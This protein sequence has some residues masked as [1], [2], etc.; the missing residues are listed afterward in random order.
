MRLTLYTDYALRVLMHAALRQP[1]RVTIDEVA[2]AYNISRNHLVKVVQDLGQN[3]FLKTHR[4]IGGGFILGRPG[5]E[6]SLGE[7]IRHT[8]SDEHVV[9]CL[10]SRDNGCR[11][12]PVCRL[13]GV[14]SEASAAFFKVLDNYTIADLVKNEVEIK[15]SLGME[16]PSRSNRK[17][18]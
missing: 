7:V 4:G 3:G 17:P 5:G 10:T 18:L 12:F 11:I 13:K 14:L 15:R 2:D 16:V 9:D 8:E 6:I 1:R